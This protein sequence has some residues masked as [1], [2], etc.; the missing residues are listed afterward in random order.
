MATFRS[1][2]FHGRRRVVSKSRHFGKSIC[3]NTRAQADDAPDPLHPQELRPFRHQGR[4]V[5]REAC[6]APIMHRVVPERSVRDGQCSRNH[7]VEELAIIARLYRPTKTSHGADL[8]PLRFD[9][10]IQRRTTHDRPSYLRSKKTHVLT[11]IP[12]S[13]RRWGSLAGC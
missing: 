8:E 4:S 5:Q 12:I 3:Q 2:D 1:C 13:R 7:L 10:C 9:H 6:S 11:G